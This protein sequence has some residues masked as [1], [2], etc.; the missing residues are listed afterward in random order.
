MNKTIT[1]SD[2]EK[3]DFRI[4]TIIRVENNEKARRPA[5]KIWVDFGE[6]GIKQS[7]AQ[8]TDLYTKKELLNK[9]VICVMNF[10]TK[11]IAGFKSEILI[12]G[13]YTKDNQVIL[14]T[15]DKVIHNGAK[16]G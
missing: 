1:W 9:Q 5:Y 2:F 7:S 6:L 12:T 13:L 14:I 10:E 16:L 8:L 15:T 11:L 3:V 4:G